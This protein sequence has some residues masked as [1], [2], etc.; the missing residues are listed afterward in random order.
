LPDP[1]SVLWERAELS[2]SCFDGD[3]VLRWDEGL[4]ERL[5]AVGL[6]REINAASS[7]VCDACDFGHVEDVMFIDALAEAGARAY[8]WCPDNGRIRVPIDRLRQWEVDFGGVAR[9]LAQALNRDGAPEELVPSRLWLLG[10]AVFAARSRDVFLARGLSWPDAASLLAR[11]PRLAT[12]GAPLVL[13]AGTVPPLVLWGADV[14]P[15]FPLGAVLSLRGDRI[16]LDKLHLESGLSGRSAQPRGLTDEE[17]QQ[18]LKDR[19]AIFEEIN[20]EFAQE[21]DR[22]VVRIN[23]V[24]VAGLRRSDLKFTRLLLIA[25]TRA[26]DPEVAGGGWMEKWR[27]LGDEGDHDLEELR[28]DLKRCA[29]PDLRP[30]EMKALIRASGRRD[31]LIRLAVH[32]YRV[33]FHDS[34]GSFQFLGEQLAEPEK[35]GPRRTKG[36]RA[37][38][39]QMV[40]ARHTAEKLLAEARKLGVPGPQQPGRGE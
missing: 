28:S 13:V 36:A 24:E 32:P 34:L 14:P 33:A 20:F 39:T 31:G 3:E 37:H 23:G 26:A 1:L 22:H 25:A 8:I 21:A 38:K 16:T 11:A 10:K 15:L 18:R 29:H 30:D 27:L 7:V 2:S 6:V 5:I 12:S 19:Q 9:S 35:T 17:R 40:Q 4:L